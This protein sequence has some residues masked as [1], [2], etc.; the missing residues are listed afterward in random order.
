LV[1]V[2]LAGVIA[3]DCNVAGPDETTRLTDDPVFTSVPATGLSLITLPD[4]TELLD[5]IVTV[6]TASP[7]LSMAAVAAL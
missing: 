6:P 2:G 1:I 5:I 3:I 4:G 7:A